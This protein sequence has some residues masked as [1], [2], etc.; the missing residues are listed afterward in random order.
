MADTFDEHITVVPGGTYFLRIAKCEVD[1]HR[2]TPVY[3]VVGGD[4]AG[5]SVKLGAITLRE[6]TR[7][8]FFRTMRDLG[9]G[10]DYFVGPAHSMQEVADDLLGRTIR[11]H[12]I[13]QDGRNCFAD[14]GSFTL[15]GGA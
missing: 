15:I 7:A 4:Y 8:F 9:L 14:Y 5:R 13:E 10:K 11:A 2:L 1:K 3:G 6:N 12:V